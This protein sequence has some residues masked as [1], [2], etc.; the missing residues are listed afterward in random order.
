[1][2]KNITK[3]V[4]SSL[5]VTNIYTY[6]GK[7][8]TLVFDSNIKLAIIKKQNDFKSQYTGKRLIIRPLKK[9]TGTDLMIVLTD[10]TI[11]RLIVV[12]DSDKGYY[13]GLVNFKE[14]KI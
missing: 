5:G 4:T 14:V 3:T 12:E 11:Y 1:M 8:T 6:F 9:N 7:S 13:Y 10:Q 2:V